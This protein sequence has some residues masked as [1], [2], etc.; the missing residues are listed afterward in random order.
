M[1]ACITDLSANLAKVELRVFKKQKDERS[2]KRRAKGLGDA[3]PKSVLMG[4][5][6]PELYRIECRLHAEMGLPKP[7]PY[8]GYAEDVMH[9][10]QQTQR[11]GFVSF[12][13]IL[14]AVRARNRSDK[15]HNKKA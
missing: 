2:A 3:V 12:A 13:A 6:T 14:H 9:S 15:P 4:K 11:V 5:M 1:K 10:R 8:P 7:A